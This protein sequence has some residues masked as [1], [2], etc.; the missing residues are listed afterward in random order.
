[1]TAEGGGNAGRWTPCKSKPGLC[2]APTALGNRKRRDSHIPTATTAVSLIFKTK[3]GRRT[4]LGG[5]VEIEKHDSHFPTDPIAC[6]AR[7]NSL[8]AFF[9][10]LQIPNQERRPHG[11]IVRSSGSFFNEKMLRPI[12]LETSD[13]LARC[14]R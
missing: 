7:M 4:V 5:K 8:M 2:T 12:Y 11:R 10:A 13:A 3:T 6:G 9:S 14:C 1:M